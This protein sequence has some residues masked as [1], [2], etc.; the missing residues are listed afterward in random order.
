MRDRL[1]RTALDTDADPLE[2]THH[3]FIE[4]LDIFNE[5]YERHH[6]QLEQTSDD[7]YLDL[8]LS[9]TQKLLIYMS[10]IDRTKLK[11]DMNDEQIP[12]DEERICHDLVF[13]RLTICTI[14]CQISLNI[15][16]I[17]DIPKEFLLEHVVEHTA[18]FIKAQL[19]TIIL[20]EYDPLYC[21]DNHFKDPLLTKEKRSK[22]TG[23]KCKSSTTR[24]SLFF[25]E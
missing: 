25:K 15:M 10:R 8:F 4:L 11:Y 7:P 12:D 22:E 1:A 9:V 18:L 23:T 24:L 20:S 13:E 3:R 17:N 19:A 16:A 2:N 5:D 14:A 6:D 21:N